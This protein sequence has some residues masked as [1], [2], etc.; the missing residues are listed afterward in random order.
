MPS[1]RSWLLQLVRPPLLQ[2]GLS[3]IPPLQ[4][5]RPRRAHCWGRRHWTSIG[6]AQCSAS[7]ATRSS[8]I[9]RRR[10]PNSAAPTSRAILRPAHC[11]MPRCTSPWA[12]TI[13]VPWSSGGRRTPWITWQLSP[14][15]QPR[16]SVAGPTMITRAVVRQPKVWMAVILSLSPSLPHQEATISKR[17]SLQGHDVSPESILTDYCVAPH[18]WGAALRAEQHTGYAPVVSS[19]ARGVAHPPR[20]PPKRCALEPAAICP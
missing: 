5:R 16:V 13:P 2:L 14:W 15:S 9:L 4:L 12:S 1:P 20:P 11:I 10:R 17:S 3:C 8:R 19:M 18:R 6:L 7:C